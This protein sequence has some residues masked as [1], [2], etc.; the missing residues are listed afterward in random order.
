MNYHL[1]HKP[2]HNLLA[3]TPHASAP[4]V[5]STTQC[6]SLSATHMQTVPADVSSPSTTRWRRVISLQTRPV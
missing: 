5:I 1:G 6:C 2:I 3:V 4:R